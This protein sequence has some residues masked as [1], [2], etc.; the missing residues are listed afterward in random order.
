MWCVCVCVCVCVV[1][2]FGVCVCVLCV[3]G[4]GVWCVVC[5]C[6]CVSVGARVCPSFPP[7]V[8]GCFSVLVSVR[9]YY[10]CL[11]VVVF[12]SSG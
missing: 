4:R 5:V 2:V 9:F 12:H 10:L 6:L 8:S 3:C 7:S 11:F 1:L